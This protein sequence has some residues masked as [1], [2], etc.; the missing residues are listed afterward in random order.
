MYKIIFDRKG[1]IERVLNFKYLG[2]GI[3]QQANSHGEIKKRITTK[4]R[5]YFALIT[6]E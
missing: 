6:L 5:F 3:N 4:N 2:V 1:F